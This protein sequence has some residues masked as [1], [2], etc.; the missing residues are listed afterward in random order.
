M[1]TDTQK[2]AE[3]V[4]RIMEIECQKLPISGTTFAESVRLLG[5]LLDTIQVQHEMLRE[6]NSEL[7]EHGV[8]AY[9]L[10]E[11]ITRFAPLMKPKGEA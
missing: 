8:T 5:Q 2:T 9:D 4:A 1:T 7:F 6:Y 3:A 11:T 10:Q